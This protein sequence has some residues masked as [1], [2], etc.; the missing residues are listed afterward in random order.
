MKPRISVFRLAAAGLVA[1]AV[2]LVAVPG[3]AHAASESSCRTSHTYATQSNCNGAPVSVGDGVCWDS[4]AY[5]VPK[6]QVTGPAYD[7]RFMAGDWEYG[8][9]VW[10]SPTCQTNWAVARVTGGNQT[11]CGVSVATKIRREDGP[12]GPYQIWH[13]AWTT[14]CAYNASIIVS[15]MVWSPDNLAQACGSLASD[16]Q[17]VCTVPL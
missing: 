1:A 14:T 7:P 5:P 16:D 12:D 15:P 17:K 9:N 13:S 6:G 10:Y 11:Q 8:V 4:S 2:T 3:V